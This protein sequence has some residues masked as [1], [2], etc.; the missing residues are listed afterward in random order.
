[1]RPVAQSDGDSEQ[2]SSPTQ[3]VAVIGDADFISNAYLGNG[4]NL[5]LGNR[6]VNWLSHDDALIRI[7]PRTAPDTQLTLTPTLSLAIGLG[8][9]AVIPLGL[10]AAG[11]T[12]WWRRRKR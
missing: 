10:L 4:A 8:F 9:L 3:R 12:I 11:G 2:A 1:M 5:D 7:P 6:L